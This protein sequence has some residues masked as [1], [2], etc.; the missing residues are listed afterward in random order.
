MH[1]T[2]LHVL[3]FYASELLDS[4]DAEVEGDDIPVTMPRSGRSMPEVDGRWVPE[5]K[6]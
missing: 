4:D 2:Q 6:R 5:R 1:L 3:L